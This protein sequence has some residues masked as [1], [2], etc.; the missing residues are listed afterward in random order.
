MVMYSGAPVEQADRRAAYYEAHHPY[1][2]GLLES[3][4]V[5]GDTGRLRPIP[6]QPPS[7]LAE[8][9]GCAVPA[10]LPLR[11]GP[12]RHR[13][14]AAAP[15]RAP[16][17]ATSPPA[18]CPT[19]PPGRSPAASRSRSR[20]R[21]RRRTSA[22]ADAEPALLELT[23]IVKHFPLRSSSL[24]SR[25]H[26]F[27]H[28]VDGVSLAIRDGETLGLVGETGCGKSTLARCIARLQPVTGGKIVFDGQDITDLSRPGPAG[29]APRGPD[30]VPGPVRLAQPAPPHRRHRRRA[31]G[32][33]RAGAAAP[34]RRD[35]V[36]ELMAMVGLN[37]EHYNRY[38][39]EF[40]GGQRQRV[41][42]ARALAVSPKLL[43]CDEP[44]SALDVS[45]QAQVI[46][47]LERPAGRA[48]T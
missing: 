16:A 34:R 27:V 20:S 45:V 7:M 39:A 5:A 6:G 1:T 13:G 14:A 11:P 48:R 21:P 33:A 29:G 36:Q 40:S 24:L 15:G 19:R 9:P 18:G 2:R 44:V 4:P 10:A 8:P 23:G 46:N 31:A 35:R 38:P 41:G 17:P 3:I 25:E 43:I 32:R 12:V 42:I 22:A 26:R 28:A 30:G 37:P 47:L